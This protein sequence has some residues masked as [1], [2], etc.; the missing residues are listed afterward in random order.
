MGIWLGPCKK[1]FKF[2]KK[3]VISWIMKPK[4]HHRQKMQL[5]HVSTAVIILQSKKT[6]V[7]N[8]DSYIKIAASSYIKLE[9]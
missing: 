4:F 5:S 7:S 6:S 1:V 3:K 9:L 8:Y 2:V